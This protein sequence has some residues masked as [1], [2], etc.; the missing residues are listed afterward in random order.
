MHTIIEPNNNI[1]LLNVFYVNLSSDLKD[2]LVL[3]NIPFY[4]LSNSAFLWLMASSSIEYLTISDPMSSRAL[5]N[6]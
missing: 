4:F 6:T 1:V 3:P 2:N 5:A